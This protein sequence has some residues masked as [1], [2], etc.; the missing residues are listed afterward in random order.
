M[1][2]NPVIAEEGY[3]E[4][5]RALGA[6]LDALRLTTIVV[7]EL[8]DRLLVKGEA[9]VYT[10]NQVRG[11]RQSLFIGNDELRALVAKAREQRHPGEDE[12]RPT[13]RRR[14]WGRG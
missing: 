5:F 13:S 14:W 8:P 7:T 1:A 9:V 3:E 6:H 10:E 4:V 11:V 12:S 2:T